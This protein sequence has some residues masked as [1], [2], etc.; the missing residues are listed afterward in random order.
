MPNRIEISLLHSSLTDKSRFLLISL[1]MDAILGET[2]AYGRR[3]KLET[4]AQGL[5]L[6]DVYGATL[7]RIKEQ[8]GEKAR[9]GMRALLWISHSE[10]LLQL[11]EL[12]HALAVEIGSMD[13]DAKRIPSVETLLSCCL[14]L[15][16]VDREASTVRLIHYTLQE[17][18]YTCPDLFGAT[19][20][21]MAETCLTYLN[22]QTIKEIPAALLTLPQSTP[23]LKYSS[24]YWGA[25]ARREASKSV[26]SLALKLFSQIESHISTRL[27]LVD[28]I[29][30]T[31][32]YSR[33]I[34]VHGHLIGFTGLH[35]A[36][37]FGIVEI[38]ASFLAQPNPNLNKRD[39]LGI[40]PLIWAAICGKKEVAKLLLER[41]TVN[42]DQPDRYF[43]RTALSWAAGKGHEGI[44]RLLLEQASAKSDGTDGW[45]GKTP[46][47]VNMVRGRR[48][49]DPN[50]P[51]KYG[52]TAILLAT[53]AGREEVVKLLLG[54]KDV[55][56]DATDGYGR[57]PLWYASGLG[58][59]GV[60]KLLVAR[61]DVNIHR[62][63]KNGA[64]P[65]LSAAEG[66]SERVVGLLL[67][68][69]DINPNTCSQTGQTA[70]SLASRKG[71]D[72][73]VKL[74]LGWEDVNPSMPD[75]DRRTPLSWAA[76][77][78]HDGVVKL[79]LEREDVNPN[80][81]DNDWRTPLSWA[82]ESGRDGAVKLLLEREDLNPDMPD[83]NRR[84]PLSLASG[85]GMMQLLS[86]CWGGKTL[87][88][89]C[90]TVIVEHP[91]RWLPGMGV[92]E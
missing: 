23:F 58:W 25:H 65:L 90:Q 53:E 92:I 85:M 3:K 21:I 14:G 35:C 55:K 69:G 28:L 50:R 10:R 17:Y 59:E 8:G 87:T 48:C 52:Q 76:E 38:A 22:F 5:D 29:S 78:G 63:D 36:S 80:M 81:P 83:I 34:P 82:A 70:L 26:V 4:I 91:S 41:Q 51:D 20:S 32:R 43:N 75:N 1:T 74:L 64:T 49:V 79:L 16:V 73:I 54:R 46:R 9:L 24:L 72:G 31:G 88:P 12:F 15:V 44:V 42:P 33:D 19:H 62:P 71:R 2:T 30:M 47:V 7:Q 27:L 39:F 13:L 84:T 57:T 60:V 40:T 37:V 86:Y 11:D 18:L 89:I 67:E 6:K 45:W 77:Y 61:D 66:G 68:R 56:P